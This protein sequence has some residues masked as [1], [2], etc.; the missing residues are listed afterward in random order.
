MAQ[1][2]ARRCGLQRRIFML[3]AAALL[4]ALTTS[5]WAGGYPDHPIR[6][7]VPS[8]AGGG[9]DLSWRRIESKIGEILGQRIILENHPGATGNI[10]AALVA[11]APPDGYTLLAVVSSHTINPSIMKDVP[12][13]IEKDFAP[14]SLT[15]TVPN[16]LVSNPALPAKNVK[17]LIA[18]IKSKPGQLDYGSA[19][20]GSMPHLMMVLFLNSAGVKMTHIPYKGAATA[21]TDVVGGHIALMAGNILT[22]MP[23]VKS[24]DLRAYGVTSARRSA[25][26]PD[27]PTLAEAGLPGYDAVQWFGLAAP[28]GTPRDIIMKLHAAVVTALNDPAVHDALVHDGADPVPSASPEEFAAYIHAERLKWA[29]VAEDAGL[30][31]K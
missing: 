22:A 15:L 21:F 4:G 30:S 9:T 28:A 20:V 3:A 25:A 13:D 19:G 7:I 24:G 14:I 11:Q 6:L 5:A 2:R 12:Y 10:G 27:V 23:L 8:A 17:E 31:V 26:A 1:T 29:K 16:V 18:Y